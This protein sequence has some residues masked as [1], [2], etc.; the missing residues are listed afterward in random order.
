MNFNLARWTGAIL[1]LCACSPLAWALDGSVPGING[2]ISR[3]LLGDGTGVV[4]GIVDSGVDDTHPALTGRMNAESNFVTTEPGN[5]GDDVYGHGTWVSSAALGKDA[6]Y[7]GMAPDA[8]YVNARVLD[9]S[10]GFGRD[11]QVRN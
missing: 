6:T 4:I 7:M 3:V 1:I 2:D 9:A 8:H 11:I 10:N 5:T